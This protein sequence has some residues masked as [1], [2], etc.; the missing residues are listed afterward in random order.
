[1][2][3]ALDADQ[4]GNIHFLVMQYVE[5]D[6]LSTMVKSHGPLSIDLAL[7]FLVQT[8]RGLEY[9]HQEGVIHRDIK[10]SNLIVAKNGVVKILDMGLARLED[11]LTE[12]SSAN[13]NLT[14]AGNIM[15]TVDFM[16][17]EQTLDAKEA[18]HRADI[19]GLGCTLYYL[20]TGLKMY[21]ADTLMKRI[22]AHRCDP[23]PS[24]RAARADAPEWLEPIFQKLVA[25]DK[26]DRYQSM[27]DVLVAVMP[28]VSSGLSGPDI[29]VSLPGHRSFQRILRS[30]GRFPH[31]SSN[32]PTLSRRPRNSLPR[33]PHPAPV[34]I[35]WPTP[36]PADYPF[37]L[38][39][40]PP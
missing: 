34:V 38:Q 20:L 19:Y 5:G 7:S 31:C 40:N 4:A 12:D 33:R 22:M 17:P 14:Q 30:R 3:T 39:T 26:A 2:V 8:V 21:D 28:H 13:R 35:Q 6:N 29:E 15:G 23:I 37:P 11:S 24:L 25:K 16:A 9:A 1:M 18:D 10:P 32:S 27:T 36:L